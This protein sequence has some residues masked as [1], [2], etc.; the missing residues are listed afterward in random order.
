MPPHRLSTVLSDCIAPILKFLESS[1]YF[2]RRFDANIA[3]LVFGN[4][5][6]MPIPEVV[7][8]LR[9]KIEPRDKDWFAYK[10]T[11]AEPAKAVAASLRASTGLE[12]ESEDVF[13]TN[14][15]F[16]AI[17]AALRAI[18]AEGDEVV[19]LTPPW[20]FYE[21][22]I[23]AT[24]ARPKRLA[25]LPPR[26]TLDADAISAVITERTRAVIVNS[27]HNPSGRIFDEAELSALSTRL[28]HASERAGRTVFLLSDESYR[29]IRFD[30]RP[31]HSPANYYPNTLI[32]Y[33]YGKALLTPGQRLG[34]IALPPTMHDRAQ[35]RRAL[36]AS[37]LATG[38]AFPN[39]LMQYALPELEPLCIDVGRLEQRRDRL[40]RALS[41]VG[42]ELIKPE[43]TFYLL[44]RAP[45]GDDEAFTE[46][47][48]ENDTFVLPGDIVELPGWVRLSLTASDA[49]IERA[50]VAFRAL[51]AESRATEPSGQTR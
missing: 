25:L 31:F 24:G 47:L 3:D 44:V 13:L 35:L 51:A 45:G 7:Q 39:A 33:T 28:E 41:A 40:C 18:A 12:F 6:D 43:G 42:Y 27:P 4:P 50:I 9:E 10:W 14:G 37:Q 17:A 38:Y 26:F 32:L 1:T 34:Y 29:R 19:F 15:A 2:R 36:F 30:G 16:A 21:Q 23:V 11:E 49:M 5:H 20:F 22:M 8:A 46:R 48:A